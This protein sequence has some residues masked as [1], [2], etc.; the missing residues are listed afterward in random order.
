[1]LS[2]LHKSI[3]AIFTSQAC[4][5]SIRTFDRQLS[6]HALDVE[7]IY[8]YSTCVNRKFPVIAQGLR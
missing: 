4:E 1:M 2:I 8:K 7:V 6:F 3:I 5:Y